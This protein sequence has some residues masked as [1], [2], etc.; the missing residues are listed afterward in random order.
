MPLSVVTDAVRE[1][2]DGMDGEERAF[3]IYCLLRLRHQRETS[4]PE[5][6]MRQTEPV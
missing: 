3:L 1:R 6:R 4:A 2:W 5:P